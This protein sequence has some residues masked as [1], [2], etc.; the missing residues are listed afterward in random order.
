MCVGPSGSL[1]EPCYL[2]TRDIACKLNLSITGVYIRC[3]K[4]K[5]IWT[6][7]WGKK[8]IVHLVSA[9]LSTSPFNISDFLDFFEP[10]GEH[11]LE[12]SGEDFFCI[13]GAI[14]VM[15][16]ADFLGF[17]GLKGR[18]S[19]SSRSSRWESFCSSPQCSSLL[20]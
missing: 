15:G 2:F 10:L 12:T 8:F 4:K 18:K 9:T 1:S 5:K 16:G 19:G 11:F 7:W 20:F 17:L 14:G 6:K 13:A 3:I